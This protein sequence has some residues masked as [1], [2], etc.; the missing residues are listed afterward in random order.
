MNRRSR[1][2]A[3]CPLL[4]CPI[5]DKQN[6]G[7]ALQRETFFPTH[8]EIA[9]HLSLLSLVHNQDRRYLPVEAARSLAVHQ[10]NQSEASLLF[11]DIDHFKN[12]NDDHGHRTGDAA[13]GHL[14][15]T[16]LPLLRAGY[17]IVRYGGEEFVIRLPETALS[18]AIRIAERMRN[19]VVSRPLRPG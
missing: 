17:L 19:A 10:R 16:W 15:R 2:H 4:A 5:F 8:A 1:R 12:I 3:G 6:K 7:V 18:A 13:I 14:V 11:L 9:W